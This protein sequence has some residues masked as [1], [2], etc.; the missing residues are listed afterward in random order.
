MKHAIILSIAA[1]LAVSTAI[2]APA[3]TS[4]AAPD[5]RLVR[6]PEGGIQPQ[7]ATAADGTVHMIYF[8]GDPIA[9]DIDYVRSTDGGASFSA[10][11]RVNSHPGAAVAVGN[12]RGAQ[13]ALGRNGLVHVAWNGSKDGEPRGPAGASPML[14]TRLNKSR[15]AFE[16]ERDVIHSAFGL[17]GGGTLAA[18][19]SGRV[20]VF[21]HAPSPGT[22]GEENRR[23][24]VARSTDDGK[25]FTPEVSASEGATGACGCCGMA[26]F[27][28]PN[29]AVLALF[30]SATSV[31]H[32]D[33]YLLDSTN[34][35]R[36][37]KQT[38]IDP[39]EVGYCV[40]S[41]AH[42]TAGGGRVMAAWETKGQIDFGEIDTASGNIKRIVAAPGETGKRK[43]PAI[44]TN[45]DRT[46]V[47]WT[48]GMGWKKGG[49]LAWQMYDSELRPVGAAGHAEGVPAWSLIAAFARPDGGFTI[50][51]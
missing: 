32:R 43:H 38:K 1:G 21:W 29:G 22:K 28:A 12:I 23:V 44:A 7:T 18:D 39:W 25:T 30:R 41:S 9:G 19:Q 48:E 47:A 4:G 10:P 11:I 34:G 24:W 8:T 49:S 14:Y 51:Y 17:D 2:A 42:F 31:V 50:V 46:L 13:I 6:V 33:M 3:T 20:Y 26:A 36:S 5:V 45:G 16:P 15:T 37:F 27:A 40:M 35:G